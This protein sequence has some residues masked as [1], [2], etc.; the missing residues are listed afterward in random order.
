MT[1]SG[2]NRERHDI[3]IITADGE[4]NG[5]GGK[6]TRFC[7]RCHLENPA[8]EYCGKPTIAELEEILH[9]PEPNVR[10]LPDGSCV[11][12]D[13]RD[14]KIATLEASL[15]STEKKVV[16]LTEEVEEAEAR[17]EKVRDYLE[18]SQQIENAAL[19]AEV[20]ALRKLLGEVG[21]AMAIHPEGSKHLLVK[22]QTHLSS[23]SQQGRGAS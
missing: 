2:T 22:I 7:M 21:E 8:T 23:T 5:Q 17:F 18:E 19:K 14:A 1:T 6:C 3:A 13:E 12:V 11:S 20:A 10:V 4:P 15:L 9:R 16:E